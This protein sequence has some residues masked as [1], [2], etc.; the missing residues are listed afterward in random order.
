MLSR[1]GQVP[2]LF[3]EGV[4]DVPLPPG[5]VRMEAAAFLEKG[6]GLAPPSPFVSRRFP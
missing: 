6:Q 2:S 3:L 4:L 1:G 5:V